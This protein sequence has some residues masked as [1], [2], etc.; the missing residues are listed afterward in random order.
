MA[1]YTDFDEAQTALLANADFEEVG[2]VSKAK[3]FISAA[4]AWLILVPESSSNQSSSV[5]IGKSTVLELLK[6]ARAFVAANEATSSTTNVRFLSVAE[7][8]R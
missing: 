5:S 7:G 3:T 8:F 1:T 4:N 2:S 6:R